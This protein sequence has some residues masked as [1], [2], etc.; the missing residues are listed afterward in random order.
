MG[1]EPAWPLFPGEPAI[2]LTAEMC[3]PMSGDAC[4][5]AGS[6]SLSTVSF[7]PKPGSLQEG[8]G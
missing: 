6:H 8:K 2:P 4:T 1:R 3:G 7:D 5:R